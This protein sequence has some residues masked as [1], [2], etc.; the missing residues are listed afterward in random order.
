[1]SFLLDTHIWLWSLLNPQKLDLRVIEVLENKDS[2]LFISPMS[3]WETLILAEKGRI[4]LHLK[5]V[6]WIKKAFERCPVKEAKLTNAIAIRIRRIDLLRQR[7]S[8]MI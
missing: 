8:N 3:I 2:E 4:K 1:M 6:E 7:R 5:P